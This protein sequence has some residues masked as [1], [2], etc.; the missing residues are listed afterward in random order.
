MAKKSIEPGSNNKQ[1]YPYPSRYGSHKSMVNE[2]QTIIRGLT[3]NKVVL[4]D[5]FGSYETERVRLDDKTCDHN[6]C[7]TS[8]LGKLFEKSKDRKEH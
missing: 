2:E 7:A 1:V 4:D 8:R 3:A 6:R 5:E